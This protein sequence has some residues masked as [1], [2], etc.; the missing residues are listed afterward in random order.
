VATYAKDDGVHLRITAISADADSATRAVDQAEAEIR[1]IVGNH[2]YGYLDDP[3]STVILRLVAAQGQRIAVWEAGNAGHLGVLLE[4]S[5]LGDRVV[6][7]A[8]TT[9]FE[10]AVAEIG[11]GDDPE[12][13]A[14]ACATLAANR[15]GTIHGA[16]IAIRLSPGEN[17]DR[18]S[19]EIA[20]ALTIN[21]Q[22]RVRRNTV[23]AVTP[24]IRRRATL[25]AVDFLWSTLRDETARQPG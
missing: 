17:P 1:A 21:G 19:G 22:A 3:I 5:D 12:Q 18:A 16:A 23:S 9:S 25:Q 6:A 14:I 4:E 13:V 15:A 24:E 10:A 2:V 20:I 11:S 8:R 7:D